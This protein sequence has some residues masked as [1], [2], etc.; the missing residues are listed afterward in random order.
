MK[1]LSRET[2]LAIGLFALLVLVTVAAAVQQGRKRAAEATP[3]FTTISSAPDGVRALRL[4]LEELGYPVGSQ[5]GE[6]FRPPQGAGLVL[7]LEPALAITADEWKVLDAWVEQGGTLLLA[8]EGRQAAQAAAHYELDMVYLGEEAESL[9]VQTPLLASPPLTGTARVR[10]WARFQADRTDLVVHL[11]AEEGP[12][13]VSLAQGA[14]RVILSAAPFPFTNAGLKEEGNPALVLNLVS[15][16]GRA[17]LVWFDEWHHGLRPQSA[18]EVIGPEEWL[19]Y[20][21]AGHALLFAAGVAFLALLLRGRR[22]G[23]P[24]PLPKSVVRRPPLEY[25]TAIANLS[26]RAGH[27]QPVLRDYHRWLKRDLGRRYRLD[28]ALPDEE[29]VARLSELSPD[30]DAAA[31]RSLLARLSR[32]GASEGEMVQWAAEVARWLE[33]DAR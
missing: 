19:R 23:R 1:R 9:A 13:L 2:W 24:V 6:Q 32:G 30:L 7:V 21:P 12:V 16:A 25:V 31:L 28:A 18:A 5:S 17:G 10:A 3:P 33:A 15:A 8:G 29:Y 14:G 20:T 26:R 11:A 27:R 22:F 4:W